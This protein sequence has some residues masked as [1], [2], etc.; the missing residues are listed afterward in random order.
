MS[1]YSITKTST[2]HKP[3]DWSLIPALQINTFPWYEHG[4]KQSSQVKLTAN[5]ST[6]FI[7]IIAQDKHSYAKQ[8]ELNHMLICQDSCVE[9]F[10]SPSGVLGSSYVN[11]EVNC[12]GTLHLAYGEDR[13]HRQFISLEAANLIQCTS[14]LNLAMESPVKLETENDKEWTIDIALPFTAIEALTGETVNKDKWFAN[15]YRCGGRTEPQYAVWNNINVVEPDY[16][17]PEHFGELVFI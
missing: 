15:F 2:N 8:T 16:H 4:A 7:Q 11:L 17:R 9:F 6:L 13:D 1:Q 3:L 10:F 14:S 12:C 5:N